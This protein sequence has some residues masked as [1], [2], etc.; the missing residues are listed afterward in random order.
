MVV[1]LVGLTLLSLSCTSEAHR[2]RDSS[3]SN[4]A[5]HLA[6]TS[7]AAVKG[8][9]MSASASAE[10]NAMAHERHMY[11]VHRDILTECRDA[12]LAEEDRKETRE[13][14]RKLAGCLKALADFQSKTKDQRLASFLAN[15]NYA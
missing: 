5:A 6:A 8:T 15:K 2:D 13:T 12:R 10:A 3:S 7:S 4:A 11:Q 1:Q 9:S 14:A